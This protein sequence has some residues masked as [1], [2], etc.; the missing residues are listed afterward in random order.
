MEK[1]IKTLYI[2]SIAAI[3]AFLGM[4]S[5]WLYARYDYSLK[6]YELSAQDVIKLTVDEYN[7]VRLQ[8]PS[9]I[10]TLR[11]SNNLNMYIDSAGQQRRTATVTTIIYDTSKF[12][13]FDEGSDLTPEEQKRLVQILADSIEAMESKKAT[14]DVSNAPSDGLAWNAMRNYEMELQSPFSTEALDSLLRRENIDA[15][16][17]IIVADSILWSTTVT[18]HSSVLNPC[19]SMSVPYSELEGKAVVI[20]CRIPASEVIRDM[21]WTLVTACILS[22]LLISCLVWQIKTIAKLSRLDKMRNSFITTMI[23]ELKRPISTLKMCVSGID[24]DKLMEDPRLRHEW[25]AETRIALDNLSAYFSKLRDITFNNVEQIPLNVSSFPLAGLIDGALMSIA[26][27]GAKQVA[28]ENSVPQELLVSADR[29]HLSNVIVNLVEN[30]VK[31]SGEEVAVKIG[32]MA[33]SEGVT[34]TVSDNGNG[35][36]ASDRKRIFGRF[37]R[38]KASATDIPGMGLGLTYV[39]LLVDAH[40]GDISVESSEGVGTTF[41]IKLPQ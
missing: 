31:Y 18:P 9:K 20:D 41:T 35:I 5:Y 37:Y 15:R 7:G 1:K 33:T 39:K 34:I 19:F 28:I 14:F 12:F 3:L 23:H 4:Q 10:R 8:S 13:G 27:P 40:G 11:T 36:A 38:G 26:I 17:S 32:A 25:V 6:E 21:L 2:F 22:L 29:S 30:A 24:S 16:V